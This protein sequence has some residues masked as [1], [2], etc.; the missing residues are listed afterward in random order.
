MG[1]WLGGGSGFHAVGCGV[2]LFAE[3]VGELG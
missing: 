2:F 3:D 1:E